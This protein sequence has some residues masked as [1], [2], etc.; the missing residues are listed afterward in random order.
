MTLERK[1]SIAVAVPV[2]LLFGVFA[3][4]RSVTIRDAGVLETTVSYGRVASALVHELQKERGMTSGF[5]GSKGK[6]FASQLIGQ[7]AA[8]DAGYKAAKEAAEAV[9]G[10]ASR[11]VMSDIKAWRGLLDALTAHRKKIDAFEIPLKDALGRYTR[12]N[13]ALLSSFSGMGE[14]LTGAEGRGQLAALYIYLQMKERAGI[15]RAALSNIFGSDTLDANRLAWVAGLLAEQKV[16]ARAFLD[17]A[18]HSMREVFVQTQS[19]SRFQAPQKYRDLVLASGKNEGFG[20]DPTVW[21]K[22]QTAKIDLLKESEDKMLDIM[23][24]D[25][26]AAATEAWISLLAVLMGGIGGLFVVTRFARHTVSPVTQVVSDIAQQAEAGRTISQKLKNG[27]DQVVERSGTQLAAVQQSV[28]AMT[29]I[30]IMLGQ[31]R[32][33]TDSA[34]SKAVNIRGR[35]REGEQN[36][37]LLADAM[38]AIETA[39]AQLESFD[40]VLDGLSAKTETIDEIVFK[41]RILALNASIEAARAGQDGRGFSVV[42][43]EV[44]TL[45]ETSGEAARDI[46]TT[47]NESRDRVRSILQASAKS[48]MSG[49]EHAASAVEGFNVIASEI[50]SLTEQLQGIAAASVEQESGVRQNEVAMSQVDMASGENATAAQHT[51]KYAM[52]IKRQTETLSVIASELD[53]VV[54]GRRAA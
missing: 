3:I 52:D 45:A 54:Y 9:S 16:T 28:S 41:T 14:A 49:A 34:S 24:D 42:A 13:A 23:T 20:A 38:N 29:E 7:R 22:T 30:S 46:A 17:L 53:A 10:Q 32:Q 8:V 4:A 26:N 1:L 44:G 31:T 27:A 43:A 47:L 11:Q 12:A 50:E 33:Q 5:L 51:S 21:F 35:S 25:A 37:A 36:M 48:V 39:V 18:P 6:K 19:E 40:K 15:E 2:A